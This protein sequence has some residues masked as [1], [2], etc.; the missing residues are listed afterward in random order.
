M[1]YKSLDPDSNAGYESK[2]DKWTPEL[3]TDYSLH[4]SSE[5]AIIAAAIIK[6]KKKKNNIH[7]L[8]RD[9]I[10]LAVDYAT[11]ATIFKLIVTNMFDRGK[12]RASYSGNLKR[13]LASDY[14]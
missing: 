10:I 7:Y 2:F 9:W 13:G 5:S 1:L 3:S 11:V 8:T 14:S 12:R 6:K 4:N